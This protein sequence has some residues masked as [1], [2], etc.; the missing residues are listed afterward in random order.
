MEMQNFSDT[1]NTFK[2][3]KIDTGLT[4]ILNCQFFNLSQKDIIGKLK[5][6][7]YGI[8]TMENFSD[9]GLYFSNALVFAIKNSDSKLVNLLLKNGSSSRGFCKYPGYPLYCAIQE[10]SLLTDDNKDISNLIQIIEFLVSYGARFD[11]YIVQIFWFKL[12]N[13][14]SKLDKENLDK[15]KTCYE[16]SPFDYFKYEKY[17]DNYCLNFHKDDYKKI[18]LE[19]FSKKYPI[20]RKNVISLKFFFF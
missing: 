9:R 1:D 12:E 10:I 17:L 16:K 2:T 15:L 19:R 20:K 18:M 3:L 13:L 6:L 11:D 7:K 8:D 14:F 4:R 5:N